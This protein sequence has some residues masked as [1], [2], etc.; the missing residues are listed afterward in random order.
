MISGFLYEARRKREQL[1]LVVGEL[2]HPRKQIP[3]GNPQWLVIPEKG[4]LTGIA[5]MA[6]FGTGKTSCS[7][8]P[9]A[10]RILAS[11]AGDEHDPIF[12]ARHTVEKPGLESEAD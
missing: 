3:P 12:Y 10:E 8:Y 9:F 7:M 2:H 6:A 4:L 1:F 5:I 11:R